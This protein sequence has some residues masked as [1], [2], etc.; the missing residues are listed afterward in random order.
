VQNLKRGEYV[1]R[2]VPCLINRRSRAFGY[3]AFYFKASVNFL[4]GQTNYLFRTGSLSDGLV[5]FV[6]KSSRCTSFLFPPEELC[7]EEEVF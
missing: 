5:L 3:E 1:E 4:T 7:H 6:H 2:K